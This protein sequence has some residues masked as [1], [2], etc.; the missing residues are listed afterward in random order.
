MYQYRMS[1]MCMCMCAQTGVPQNEGQ[2]QNLQGPA[3]RA[4]VL[5]YKKMFSLPPRWGAIIKEYCVVHKL[6]C[7]L[8]VTYLVGPNAQN[9]VAR[10]MTVQEISEY[11]VCIRL[12]SYGGNVYTHV[13]AS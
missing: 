1:Y 12:Y 4:C 3:A 5:I 8:C 13:Y 2:T 11:T 7:V 10:L 9:R 6:P